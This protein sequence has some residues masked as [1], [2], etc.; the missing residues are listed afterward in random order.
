MIFFLDENFPK[1][2]HK[3]LGDAGHTVLDIRGTE[4]E[5]L[6]DNE[7]FQLAKKSKSVFLTTDK[8][9]YH[10]IHLTEKP[11]FGIIVIALKLPNAFSILARLNW[12]LENASPETE[13]KDCCYLLTDRK[14]SVFH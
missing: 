10:T 1:I 14:C 8:D 3:I 11:H 13:Y 5:G 12:F 2:T 6:P 9:Y 7:L 4:K